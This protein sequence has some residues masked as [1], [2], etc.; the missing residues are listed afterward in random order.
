MA[1]NYCFLNIIRKALFIF[2]T[3]YFYEI[4]LLQTTTCCLSCFLNLALVAYQNPFETKSILIQTAFPDLC[5]FFIIFMTILLAVHD[6]ADIFS[7][8]EKYFLGWII[9]FFIGLSIFV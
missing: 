7:F 1:L 9:L 3:V 5:I 4:P 8:D 2:C 6:V